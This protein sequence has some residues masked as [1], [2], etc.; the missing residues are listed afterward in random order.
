MCM[1]S[2]GAVWTPAFKDG[3]PGCARVREGGEVLQRIEL[4]KFCFACMLGGEDGTTLFMLVADW[5]GLEHMDA[6]FRSQTGQVL[7]TQAPAP[8]AGRP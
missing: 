8:H 7:M 2:D 5:L 1:D 4:D 3:K 6:L